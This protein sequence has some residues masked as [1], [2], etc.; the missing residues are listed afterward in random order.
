MLF[1][2]FGVPIGGAGLGR[3]PGS[4]P[5]PLMHDSVANP[6]LTSTASKAG[7][8]CPELK[9]K[10]CAA[11]VAATSADIALVVASIAKA[12]GVCSV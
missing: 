8:A 1:V 10:T 12:I 6:Q 7:V 9:L 2:S 5:V 4:G 11:D 3:A